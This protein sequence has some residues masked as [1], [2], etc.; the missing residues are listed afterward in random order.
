M[1]TASP[2]A[3]P[4]PLP[5]FKGDEAARHNPI[6]HH[7]VLRLVDNRVIANTDAQ[8]RVVACTVI[9]M[10]KDDRLLAFGLVDTHLHLEDAENRDRCGRLAQRVGSSLKQALKPVVRFVPVHREPIRSQSHLYR[11]FYYDLRQQDHH[12]VTTNPYHEASNLPDLLGLRVRGRQLTQHVRTLRPRV[13]RNDLL[14]VLGVPALPDDAAVDWDMLATAAAAAAGLP[15]LSGRRA[16]VVKARIAAV[17][18]I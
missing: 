12:G 3:R 6:G 10:A 7:L 14:E 8:R 4:L 13:T 15:N 16:E 17:H 1:F 18:L 5:A 11:A 2:V 9:E